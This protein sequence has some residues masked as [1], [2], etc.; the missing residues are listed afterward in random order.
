MALKLV[1]SVVS[2]VVGARLEAL[3]LFFEFRT[4]MVLCWLLML[5]L[6]LRWDWSIF[7]PGPEAVAKKDGAFDDTLSVPPSRGETC[8]AGKAVADDE[9]E[10]TNNPPRSVQL[11]SDLKLLDQTISRLRREF[12]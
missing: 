4:I 3:D 8:K 5:L 6:R 12:G 10:G 1:V 11:G 7:R 2:T 9:E